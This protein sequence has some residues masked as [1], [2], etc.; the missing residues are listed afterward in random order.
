MRKILTAL[1]VITTVGALAAPATALSGSATIGSADDRVTQHTYVRH[2]GGTDAAIELCN[3][4]APADYGNRTV[5][6]EPFSVVDPND[7]NLIVAGW[8]DYCSDW[9]GLGFSTDGGQTWT[10][11]L[12]PGYPADTST[13][14]MQSPEYIRTNNAS[15]PLGTFDGNGHFFFG[16]ISYNGFAGPKTNADVWVAKYDVV[17]PAA[18]HGYPL[19]YLGTT[20]VGKGTPSANFLGK[21][22][23]K[24]MLEADRTGGA[25]DGNVYMCFTKF[26]GNGRGTIY[27]AA[28]KDGGASFSQPIAISGSL[29]SQGCDIA[30]EHD[31]TVNVSWRTFDTSS[32]KKNFG[33]AAVSSA[34]AGATFSKP[35]T[36]AELPGYN[37]FDGARDCGDGADAC[38]SGFVFARVPLEPRLTADPTGRLPGIYSIVQAADPSTIVPSASSYSSVGA[39]SASGLVGQGAI[40]VMRSLDHGKTWSAPYRV[41]TSTVGHQFFPDADALD[42]R[43]VVVWQDSRV[44]LAYSVQRPIGNTAAATSSGTAVVNTYAAVSTN[45]TTFG[46]TKK[47]SSVGQQPQY[48]MFDAA[49]V[50]FLGDYNWIQLVKKTDG[51][52]FGY[53]V[54]TDNRDVVPGND[55]RETTQDG[56]DVESG[57]APQPDGS[58]TRQF[59]LGGYDQNIYG[60]TIS[61]P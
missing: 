19:D 30:V 12:V 53:M 33:V 29:A 41:N 24:P 23:D 5:N 15:D 44:D 52:L 32:S 47:V 50:P 25:T 21:F 39:P 40:Y 9:M 11:S 16:A 20:R 61:I 54:W 58:Y 51:S 45:G 34:N 57:W 55:P 56:F 27:F 43:L 26:P 10:S 59:N 13:E 22:L 37:P 8:N 36:V 6:N 31:G 48:E 42:G 60:N 46:A 18:N 2:D 1:A 14:G 4:T 7:P 38:P 3:S 28:S 35:V 17:D 49:S